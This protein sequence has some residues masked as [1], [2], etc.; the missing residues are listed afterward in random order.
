MADSVETGPDIA[1]QNPLWR[2]LPCESIEALLDGIRGRTL[3]TEAIGVRIAQSLRDRLQG[4]QVQGLHRPVVHRGDRQRALAMRTITLRHVDAP[5]RESAIVCVATAVICLL[6][7]R[8]WPSSLVMKDQ[9]DVCPLARG[10]ILPGRST[11]IHPITGWRS[12]LPSSY[13]RTPIG[14]PYGLRSLTGSVRGS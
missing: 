14:S 4:Q 6:S 12:L 7:S 8:S 2:M 11:P 3:R 13:A 1:L 10:V 9:M 5:E